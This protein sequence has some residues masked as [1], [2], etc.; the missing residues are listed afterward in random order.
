M[1]EV[2]ERSW[3]EFVLSSHFFDLSIND[4][5]ESTQICI[6]EAVTCQLELC[7]SLIGKQK[8]NAV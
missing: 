8:N 6:V 4:I 3:L 2:R 5:E 7:I 1:V